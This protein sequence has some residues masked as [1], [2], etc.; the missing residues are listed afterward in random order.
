MP[1]RL[2]LPLILFSLVMVG[3]SAVAWYWNKGRIETLKVA[4]GS[5]GGQYHSFALALAKVVERK[6][7]RLRLEV[8]ETAGSAENTRLLRA[9][10]AQLALVQSDTVLDPTEQVVSPLFPELYHLMVDRRSNIRRVSD[11]KGKSIALMPVGSGSYDLFW[12]LIKHYGLNPTDFQVTTL[13]PEVALEALKTGQVD[14]VFRVTALGN[15]AMTAF[16]QNPDIELVGID[17]A[18]AL[19]LTLPAIE[20]SIIPMG[21]YNGAVP[22]PERDLPAVAVR[23]LLVTS[24]AIDEGKIYEITRILHESRN[25]LVKLSPVAAM[26]TVPDTNLGLGLSF[27]PGALAYYNQDQPSF[28]VQYA[29]AMGLLLSVSALLFSGLWQ[30]QLWLRNKQK[31]RADAYNLELIRLI[32]KIERAVDSDELEAIRC[33]LFEIFEKVI[34]DLDRDRIT[35]ESFQ[36]FRFPWEVALSTVRHRETLLLNSRQSSEACSQNLNFY[37]TSE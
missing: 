16:L 19:Q 23:S 35:S 31:N 1:K 8:L 30:L 25:E 24:K 9:N 37:P 4:T 3:A 33:H 6:S 11:L 34:I 28:L 32:E 10:R 2:T 18:A 36:A 21:A 29:E 17:Q 5:K 15:P 13:R 14:A 22:I 26:I 27:H 12:P 7:D 20:A